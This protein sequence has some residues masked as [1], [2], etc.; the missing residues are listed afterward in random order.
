MLTRAVQPSRLPS[1]LEETPEPSS[2]MKQCS[3]TTMRDR[4]RS[5]VY[6]GEMSHVALKMSRVP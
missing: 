2:H 3:D 6:S 4:R 1:I 5:S